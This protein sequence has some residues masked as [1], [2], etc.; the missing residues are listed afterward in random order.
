MKAAKFGLF[1]FGVLFFMNFIDAAIDHNEATDIKLV[2]NK[3]R[4]FVIREAGPKTK[5]KKA[6][7][8]QRKSK[9]SSKKLKRKRNKKE[10]KGGERGRKS[11]KQNKLRQDG[12]KGIK[13]KS[14]KNNSANRKTKKKEKGE[15]KKSVKQERKTLRSSPITEKCYNTS[16]F[17][18]KQVQ[19]LAI[20]FDKQYKRMKAQKKTAMNKEMKKGIFKEIA[21]TIQLAGGGNKDKLDCGGST[22]NKGRN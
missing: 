3:I 9:T 10:K 16:L 15:R 6:K 13:K 22:T 2:E 11:K 18:M 1:L 8:N 21:S 19:T 7:E 12:K 4:E 17:Y 14:K 5:K 20:N